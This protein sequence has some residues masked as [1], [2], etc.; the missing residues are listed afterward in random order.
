MRTEKVV[1]VQG[2]TYIYPHEA[3]ELLEVLS[4]HG[5]ATPRQ[6]KIFT[7]LVSNLKEISEMDGVINCEVD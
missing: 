1:T 7:D 2:K 4:L 6:T 3:K 5:K